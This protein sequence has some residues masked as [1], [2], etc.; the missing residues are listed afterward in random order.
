MMHS[1]WSDA[2]AQAVVFDRVRSH[3]CNLEHEPF[4]HHLVR[5]FSQLSALATM[6][7]HVNKAGLATA[8]GINVEWLK[9]EEATGPRERKLDRSPT[10]MQQMSTRV[11]DAIST[12][13]K[14]RKRAAALNDSFTKEELEFY[15]QNRACAVHTTVNRI[16]RTISTRLNA[17]GMPIAPP[18]ISRIYQELSNGLLAYNQAIKMKEIAV[19]FVY[20]QYNA[21]LLLFFSLIT[22]FAVGAFTSSISS[23][24]ETCLVSG[25]LSSFVVG[26]FTAMVRA[27]SCHHATPLP[28]CSCRDRVF[29]SRV[30]CARPADSP[31]HGTHYP[32]TG[33]V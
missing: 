1:K 6:G 5:L 27:R 22:P 26:S 19:P 17:G 16:L 12:K 25:V 18:I 33:L 2:A 31:Y 11:R 20:V 32:H 30:A 24:W 13:P 7:L 14:R 4:C 10:M 3:A 15:E 8:N 23:S 28:R 29:C 21:L 9:G